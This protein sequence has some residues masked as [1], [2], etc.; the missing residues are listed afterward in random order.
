MVPHNTKI[1]NLV[2]ILQVYGSNLLN[3]DAV[4]LVFTI[5]FVLM[6]TCISSMLMICFFFGVERREMNEQSPSLLLEVQQLSVHSSSD[7]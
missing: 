1:F 7:Y 6:L 3:K 5:M 2:K 4:E